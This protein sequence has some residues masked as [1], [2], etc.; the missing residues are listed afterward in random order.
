MTPNKSERSGRQANWDL[1]RSIAMFAVVVVHCGGP[2][3][4]QIGAVSLGVM[5]PRVQGRR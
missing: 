2:Y 5:A 1:L 4:G 3:L